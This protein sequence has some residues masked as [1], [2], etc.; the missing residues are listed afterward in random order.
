[1]LAPQPAHQAVEPS[2]LYAV[3]SDR[4]AGI[5]RLICLTASSTRELKATSGAAQLLL[6]RMILLSQALRVAV[7]MERDEDVA[8][9]ARRLS[10]D[11][12]HVT[13]L[14]QRS[15]RND[16]ALVIALTLLQRAVAGLQSMAGMDTNS[17]DG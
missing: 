12:R 3:L 15:G 14:V 8:E 5:D 2:S 4:T 17:N 11:L 9:I 10:S 7:L 16:Q 1:M 6:D 13:L